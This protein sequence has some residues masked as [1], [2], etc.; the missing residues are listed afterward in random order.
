MSVYQKMNSDSLSHLILKTGV[1][2]CE[3]TLNIG[4]VV[5]FSVII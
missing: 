3:V 1:N 4:K 5:L 2:V